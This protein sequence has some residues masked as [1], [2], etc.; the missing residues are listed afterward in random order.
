VPTLADYPKLVA[1]L[2]KK[3]NGVLAPK[4]IT[5]ASNRRLWWRCAEGP[6]HLWEAPVNRRTAGHG[7][8]FCANLALSVTNN[9]AAVAPEVAR[10]WH[11]RKN[12]K[13]TPR[14]VVFGTPRVVWWRCPESPAHDWQQTVVRRTR[15]GRGCP[16]C[17]GWRGPHRALDLAASDP[18]LVAQ[19]HPLRNGK[20]TPR[21]VTLGS[22]KVVWWRCPKGPEHE[23]ECAVGNR[24]GCPFCANLRVSVTNSLAAV[25]PQVAAEWH[26]KKNGKLT[27]RDVIAGTPRRVWWKCPKARDHEWTAT[28]A[29]RVNG[30]GSP[31]CVNRRLCASNS[32]AAVSPRIAREWH[33]TKNG[34][35][36]PRDVVAGT[37]RRIWWRCA[38][39]HVWS[40]TITNRA[41]L[42]SNCPE[43]WRLRRR[44][45]VATTGKRRRPVQVAAYEGARHGSVRRVK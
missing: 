1:Q 37:T 2:D 8:P 20:L 31:Y 32:L 21:D 28:I 44:Q 36:T 5:Y 45:P 41:R 35:L 18:E 23:W 15:E 12:G 6:D 39:A 27:P 10:Q 22:G 40:A 17:A 4:S 11:P 14:D 16:S 34:K 7:C 33:P 30:T 13:L 38:F 3:K 42:G 26:P 24:Q 43:C 9:L 19:W 25:A 29:N